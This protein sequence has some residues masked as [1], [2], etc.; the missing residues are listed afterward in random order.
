MRPRSILP[1]SRGFSF[2]ITQQTLLEPTSSTVD[3]AGAARGGITVAAKPA[4]IFFSG[5]RFSFCGFS[6]SAA[7][8]CVAASGVSCTT[9]R[10]DKR[11]STA[12]MSRDKSPLLAI[13]PDQVGDRLI[14]AVLRQ[15]DRDAVLELQVPAPFGDADIAFDARRELR[16]LL[17]LGDESPAACSARRCR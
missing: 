15:L 17:D 5:L 9:R 14:L 11:M 1:S 3:D 8:R 13:H 7:S 10:S 2:A 4:H 12:A 16:M 6:F